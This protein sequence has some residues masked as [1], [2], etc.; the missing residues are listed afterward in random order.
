VDKPNFS[1]TLCNDCWTYDGIYWHW[2]WNSLATANAAHWAS[3]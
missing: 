3:I 2:R 1:Y